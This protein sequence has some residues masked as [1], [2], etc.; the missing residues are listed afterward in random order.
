[1]LLAAHVRSVDN[2]HI[3]GLQ[4]SAMNHTAERLADRAIAVVLSWLHREL[5]LALSNSAI[6]AADVNNCGSPMD[7][8]VETL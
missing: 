5:C 4:P 8:F 3:A 1:M 2:G 7:R 6:L